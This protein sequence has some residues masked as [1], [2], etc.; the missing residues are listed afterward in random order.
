MEPTP[1]DSSDDDY[2]DDCSE[3]SSSSEEEIPVCVEYKGSP[4]EWD[5]S[6]LKF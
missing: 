3:M 2:D 4:L 5:D 1:E 6:N